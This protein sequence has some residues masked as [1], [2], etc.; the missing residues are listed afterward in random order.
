M[1]APAPPEGRLT[2]R[3]A[4]EVYDARDAMHARRR[5][6]NFYQHVAD[7]EI[8]ELTRLATTISRWEPELLRWHLTGLS[9]GTVE[10]TNLLVKNTKRSGFG[11]RNFDNYRHRVLLRCGHRWQPVSAP[12][13]HPAPT[14]VA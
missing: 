9:N 8:P 6:V 7:A 5:L 14:A 4:P 13:L 12:P 10:G 1:P 2:D 3:N 11:F